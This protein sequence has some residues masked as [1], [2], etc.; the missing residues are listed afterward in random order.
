MVPTMREEGAIDAHEA[1]AMMVPL[2]DG[3]G[4]ADSGRF[5]GREGDEIPW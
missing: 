3:F 1:V 5:V 4:E 2:I